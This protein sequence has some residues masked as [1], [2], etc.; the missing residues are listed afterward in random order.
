MKHLLVNKFRKELYIADSYKELLSKYEELVINH[1]ATP[2]GGISTSKFQ[3]LIISDVEIELPENFRSH[4]VASVATQYHMGFLTS[5]DA[6]REIVSPSEETLKDM[7]EYWIEGET[8][9]KYYPT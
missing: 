7:I 6:D 1:N 4:A 3:I 9:P 2:A 5:N 8:E